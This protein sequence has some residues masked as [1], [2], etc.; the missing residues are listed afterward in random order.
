MIGSATSLSHH[1]ASMPPAQWLVE[2]II[3]SSLRSCSVTSWPACA[4][5]S[6][7]QAPAMP[8]PMTETGESPRTGGFELWY[9]PVPSPA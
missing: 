7:C 5:S 1:G 9:I 2:S 4:N 3:A 8:A 6:A